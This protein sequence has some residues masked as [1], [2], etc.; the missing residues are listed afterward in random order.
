[1]SAEEARRE[2]GYLDTA[3]NNMPIGL[4][5]FDAGKRLIVGNEPY[6]EMYGLPAEVMKRGTHLRQI[7]MPAV[8]RQSGRG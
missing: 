3:V 2:R 8:G 4:V 1:V 6:R 7:L 5:M